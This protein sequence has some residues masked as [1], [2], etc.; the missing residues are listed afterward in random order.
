[1]TTFL[2]SRTQEAI[3]GLLNPWWFLSVSLSFLPQTFRQI[4]S[5]PSPLRILLSPSR[6]QDAWFGNF[7]TF[8]GPRVRDGASERVLPLLDGRTSGGK[9]TDTPT[10]MGVGGT[11]IE[12]GAGSGLWV[13]LFSDRHLPLGEGEGKSETATA[14]KIITHVYGVEPNTAHHPALRKAVA[15]AGLEGVYEI[16]P[17]GIEDL[18]LSSFSAGVNERKKKWDGNIEPESVDCIVSILCLCSIP[19][20][21]THIRELYG[22]LRPGGRWFVYEHVRAEFSW[23]MTAYQ[24]FIN[25]FWPRMIGGCQLCRPT[26]TTLREA[27]SW[28]NIDIGHPAAEQ[29][30]SSLPHILGV[31][32]K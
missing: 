2:S 27:G 30:W 28:S 24:R 11:V 25:V 14:R 15:D 32:T 6:F 18:S 1:M 31:F 13:G 5:S 23:Y 17:V 26:G 20:P 3:L 7:W 22:L 19:D 4:L 12:I 21:E 10:G 29:W 16:V 9:V 8:A